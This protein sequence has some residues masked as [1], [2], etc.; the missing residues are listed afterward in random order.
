MPV[1]TNL[2]LRL[3]A[4]GDRPDDYWWNYNFNLLDGFFGGGVYAKAHAVKVDGDVGVGG[5]ADVSGLTVTF[6]TTQ[7]STFAEVRFHAIYSI[8]K[9]SSFAVVIS[10]DGVEY[11][12]APLNIVN[13]AGSDDVTVWPGSCG[14]GVTLALG[15]HTIKIRQS[16]SSATLRADATSPA[17]LVVDYQP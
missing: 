13:A 17:T 4:V 5:L 3:L 9:V 14:V 7:V 15:S 16:G 1:S 2:G 8:T 10:V 11:T 12:F 6:A